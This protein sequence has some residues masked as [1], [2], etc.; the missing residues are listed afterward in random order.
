MPLSYRVAADYT[1]LLM[2]NVLKK[3]LPLA[4]PF[5]VLLVYP[6]AFLMKKI[7][8]AGVQHLPLC[9]RAFMNSG[10]FPV[11]DHYYEPK[12]DNRSPKLDYS[13]DRFLPGIDWNVPGQLEFLKGLV[14]REELK[15]IPRKKT[16]DN[17][18][19]FDNGLFGPGDAD[20][21]YQ[22]IRA[23][24]PKRI[25]EIGSGNSTL[26]AIKAVKANCEDDPG[27]ASEPV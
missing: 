14:F 5:L 26:M 20:Y 11:R 19:Y 23:V 9:R 4:D 8:A 25:I 24:K 17:E 13:E 15:D 1:G 10:V 6:A 22:T 7:R 21:W 18:F 27:Y 2:K 12:F 3:L 16:R